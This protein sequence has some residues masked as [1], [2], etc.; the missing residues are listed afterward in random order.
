MLKRHAEPMASR[1]QRIAQRAIEPPPGAHRARRLR[2]EIGLA[3]AIEEN[4]AVELDAHGLVEIDADAAQDVDELRVRAQPG[5]PAG[6]LLG[7]ALEHD[8][9]PA[10]AAQEMCRKQPAERAADHQRPTGG[11]DTNARC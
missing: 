3:A 5:A 9:V 4:E 1:R 11:H 10:G 8:D 7:I 6:E 2:L